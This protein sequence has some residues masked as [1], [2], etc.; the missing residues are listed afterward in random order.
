ME[1]KYKI[2]EDK[3]QKT[4]H[5]NVNTT[6]NVNTNKHVSSLS[7]SNL[8]KE[9]LLKNNNDLQSTSQYSTS[10]LN[11]TVNTQSSFKANN[12]NNTNNTNNNSSGPSIKIGIDTSKGDVPEIKGEIKMSVQD[13]KK[14]YDKNK[15]YLPTKEQ[16]IDG[17]KATN[18]ALQKSGILENTEKKKDP[19]STL[20][21]IKK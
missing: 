2:I 8:N 5:S 15:Q 19:L 21:G 17:A 1:D 9:E 16:I 18:E 20:F 14:L 12:T 10:N 7:S 11:N 3:Y 4:N 13:A 6:S